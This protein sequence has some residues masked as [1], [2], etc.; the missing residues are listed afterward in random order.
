MCTI[1]KK[2][3][4]DEEKIFVFSKEERYHGNGQDYGGKGRTLF[5]LPRKNDWINYTKKDEYLKFF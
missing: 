1:D 2:C 3:I 5:Y 4:N